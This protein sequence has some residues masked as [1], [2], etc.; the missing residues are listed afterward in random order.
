LLVKE[1]RNHE[2][3]VGKAKGGKEGSGWKK[4]RKKEKC[5]EKGNYQWALIRVMIDKL[6]HS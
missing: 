3:E 4:K 6:T 2:K 5:H 1:K